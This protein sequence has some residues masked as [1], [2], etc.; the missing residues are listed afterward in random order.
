[1]LPKNDE[2]EHI[3]GTYA[4]GYMNELA[5]SKLAFQSTIAGMQAYIHPNNNSLS[6]EL[7]GYTQHLPELARDTLLK[8]KQFELTEKDLVQA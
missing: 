4:L 3:F 5:Q 1:M 8:F 7:S 6:I 2:L